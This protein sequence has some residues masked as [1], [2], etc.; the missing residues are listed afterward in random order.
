M[1]TGTLIENVAIG[2]ATDLIDELKVSQALSMAALDAV[3]RRLPGGIFG[4]LEGT[5][6][7]LSGG[8]R[9]RL[10]LARA[11]YLNPE[12]LVLDEPTSALDSRPKPQS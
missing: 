7:G 5:N 2:S 12:V 1:R 8:E 4:K 3:V 10:G 6:G 11:L 9:Q